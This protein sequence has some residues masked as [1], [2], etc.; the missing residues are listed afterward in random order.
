MELT[1]CLSR[2]VVVSR[3]GIVCVCVL[4]FGVGLGLGRILD[5]CV[6]CRRLDRFFLR[7]FSS[8]EALLFFLVNVKYCS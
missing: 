1:L 5:M 4:V 7:G 2:M 3:N 8:G 6:E